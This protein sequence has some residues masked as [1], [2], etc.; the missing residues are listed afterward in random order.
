MSSVCRK[1]QL[2]APYHLLLL[3][4]SAALTAAFEEEGSTLTIAQTTNAQSTFDAVQLFVTC[5]AE[6]DM[7]APQAIVALRPGGMLWIAYP[8]KTAGITSDL[9]RDHGWETIKALGY[10]GV[11]QVA[12]DDTWSALRFKHQAERSTPSRMGTDYPG[13]DRV[14]KT[15]TVPADLMEALQQ[16]K[17][18][19]QFQRLSFTA[20][21]EHVVS[22]LDAKR[23]ETR[24][25]RIKKIIAQLQ[26][27]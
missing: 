26:A 20:R 1:L 4:A 19:E 25:S 27:Q 5:K 3:N 10:E 8:K 6:L 24:L 2:K 15:V 13:I 7:L 21:K 16:A 17:L 12:L 11:R 22:V 23:P 18:E 9:T 14:T